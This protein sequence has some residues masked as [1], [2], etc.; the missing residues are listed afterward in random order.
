ML[1]TNIPEYNECVYADTYSLAHWLSIF[2]PSH[3]I[4]WIASFVQPYKCQVS[5]ISTFT[6]IAVSHGVWHLPVLYFKYMVQ[7]C[8]EENCPLHLKILWL[9][10]GSSADLYIIYA[11]GSS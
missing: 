7:K 3:P 4:S 10:G 11:R 9:G 6:K 5:N 2:L 8:K 1:T